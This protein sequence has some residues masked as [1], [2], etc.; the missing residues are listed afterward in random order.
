MTQIHFAKWN[1]PYQKDYYIRNKVLY[2]KHSY[3]ELDDWYAD[4]G[5]VTHWESYRQRLGKVKYASN[6]MLTIVNNCFINNNNVKIMDS[7]GNIINNMNGRLTPDAFKSAA[8]IQLTVPS[9]KRRVGSVTT[10]NLGRDEWYDKKKP[11]WCVCDTKY[12][13]RGDSECQNLI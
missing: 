5:A 9:T 12:L 3:E 11:S 2:C 10:M 1:K 4:I 13:G 6:N 7:E 8:K